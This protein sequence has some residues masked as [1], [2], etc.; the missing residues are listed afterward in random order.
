M[1]ELIPSTKVL[2][3]S[4]QRLNHAIGPVAAGMVIDG[5]DVL[6]LGPVGL[7][8]GIPVGALAGFWLGKSLGLTRTAAL[9]CASAA[10]VYCTL[11]FTEVLPLGTLVGALSRYWDSGVG[12]SAKE[13]GGDC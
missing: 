9:L 12:I 7:I 3:N 1:S 13:T 2:Q 8:V 10:A 6:T 4:V 5:L 11:P